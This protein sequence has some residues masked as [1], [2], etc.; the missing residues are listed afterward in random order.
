[1]S[2]SEYRAPQPGPG[3]SRLGWIGVR[4]VPADIWALI[5]LVALAAVIRVLVIDNQSFWMDEALTAYETHSSFGGMLGTVAHVETTPPL[6][7]VLIWAWAHLF[8]SDEVGLRSLSTLAGIALVPIAFVAARELVSRWAGVLAA[9]FVAVNPFLVWYSQEA[10]AYM[11]LAALSGASFLWFNRA[12]EHPSGRNVAWWTAWSSLAVMTH[13]FAGFL[14][15]PEALWL[16]SVS[17]N[18]MVIAGVAIVGA[19]QAAMLPL[20]L[21]DTSHGA[22]WIAHV[23]RTS[24]VS[25]F[26]SEWSLS[27]LN[28]RVHVPAGLVAG[29]AFV[30]LIALLIA[31]G[32]DRRTRAG[33]KV[34]AAIASFVVLTPLLLGVLGHDYFLSRNEIPA[35]VPIATLVASACA[36]PRARALGT[37]VA[38]GLLIVFSWA[39]IQVQTHGYLERPDW[40]NVARALGPA[41]TTRAIYVA[42]GTTADP[43]KI[44]MSH[45]SWVQPQRQLVR[46]DEIDVVGATKR[47]ALA[48]ARTAGTVATAPRATR[49]RPVPRT[50][51][52]PGARLLARFR[53]DNWIVAR[54][55][56]T[57][58]IRV[59]IEQLISRAP[60]YFR[61]TPRSL[62]LFFQQPGR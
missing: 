55:A 15:A 19:V 62:L 54:F 39:T 7:F 53:V 44:Y 57:H 8:G 59:S 9:A 51:S 32:A 23:P 20:A 28:R 25:K 60:R 27:V 21:T 46:I 33:A 22:N 30:A 47:L 4:E 38:I 26:V 31:V 42:D 18:R 49:G 36:A 2:A 41:A 37:A 14:V 3:A 12:R 40:R 48:P 35:V 24:R 34:A 6:Y 17:R 45:V 5:G 43:L 1:M 61:A 58:P 56:L 52:P 11:L 13:F 50:N 10:R 29:A 16:L